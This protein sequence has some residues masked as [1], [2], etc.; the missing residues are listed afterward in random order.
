MHEGLARR[1]DQ[2]DEEKCTERP[3]HARRGTPGFTPT[4][5]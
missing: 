3:G 4:A 1:D 5:P 2:D